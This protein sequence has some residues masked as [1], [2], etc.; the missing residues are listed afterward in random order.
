MV[1]IGSGPA[2]LTAAIYA[3]RGGIEP[4]VVSGDEPGGQLMRLNDY[5]LSLG[6]V[7]EVPELPEPCSRI[8]TLSSTTTLIGTSKS[9]ETMEAEVIAMAELDTLNRPTRIEG[10][11]NGAA[12]NADP[13]ANNAAELEFRCNKNLPIARAST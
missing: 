4:V 2:G 11:K 6:I 9:K 7:D 5:F 3:A 8:W 12:G 1:I 13:S 10:P